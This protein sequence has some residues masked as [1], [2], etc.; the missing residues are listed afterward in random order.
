MTTYAVKLFWFKMYSPRTLWPLMPHPR[1]TCGSRTI[2]CILQY[3]SHLLQIQCALST[4]H[5]LWKVSCVLSVLI[6]F[7]E[8]SD[9]T[10]GLHDCTGKYCIQNLLTC[11]AFT[12]VLSTPF[13]ANFPSVSIPY[14]PFR[15]VL[16]QNVS[17]LTV[18]ATIYQHNSTFDFDL[19]FRQYA[20]PVIDSYQAHQPSY[21]TSA[22]NLTFSYT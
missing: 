6:A 13:Q 18:T 16:P 19:L 7:L 2:G 3:H 5:C 8:C 1:N 9:G 22:G 14:R 10:A 17:Q 4:Y 12:D 11:A 15:I 20:P 21:T